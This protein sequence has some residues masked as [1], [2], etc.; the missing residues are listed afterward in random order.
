VKRFYSKFRIGLLTFTLGL[1]SVWFGQN[2]KTS[3]NFEFNDSTIITT[4]PKLAK[5]TETFRACGMG[6][7]QGYEAI[8]R[9]ELSE[10]NLG[11]HKPDLR[12]KRVIQRDKTRI[13][14]RVVKIDSISFTIYEID[15]GKC[16]NSPNL[17]LGLELENYLRNKDNF[18]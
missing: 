14:S 4:A 15:S 2:L 9:T 6:Y 10:G 18:Q 3:E 1:A 16:I 11:C 13:I 8:D 17:A 12:D 5:F 7:V